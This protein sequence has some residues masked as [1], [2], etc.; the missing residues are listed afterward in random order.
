MLVRETQGAEER[1]E[2]SI[3]DQPDMPVGIRREPDVSIGQYDGGD[4]TAEAQ[5]RA[6][7]AAD[8]DAAIGAI[9]IP[10]DRGDEGG[11]A[12]AEQV[13]DPELA[14]EPELP[15]AS[16]AGGRDRPPIEPPDYVAS[17]EAAGEG[18]HIQ[19]VN[20]TS[21]VGDRTFMLN[22]G[23]PRQDL[24]D[25]ALDKLDGSMFAVPMDWHR[26]AYRPGQPQ[27]L[28]RT[29]FVD[30]AADPELAAKHTVYDN[31]ETHDARNALEEMDLAPKVGAV[32]RSEEAQALAQ[33]A[34]F[35]GIDYVA[36]VAASV[37]EDSAEDSAEV[38]VYP[39]QPGH[40][41]EGD[42]LI[43]GDP[44]PGTERARVD[45]VLAEMREVF[46]AHAI[47]PIGLTPDSVVID[48]DQ[49]HITDA[50][51]MR[52]FEP[53]LPSLEAGQAARYAEG[54][55][56]PER[57]RPLPNESRP[58]IRPLDVDTAIAGRRPLGEVDPATAPAFVAGGPASRVVTV[59]NGFTGES[60]MV[61]ID[62]TSM[63]T[64]EGE[65]AVRK[66]L[67]D[68]P[69]LGSRGA[70]AHV[71]GDYAGSIREQARGPGWNDIL[72]KT[73]TS[74]GVGVVKIV[75]VLGSKVVQLNTGDGSTDVYDIEL[76][77]T[78]IHTPRRP[79]VS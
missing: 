66:L 76:D 45:A 60:G 16:D 25:V 53:D 27:D 40:T 41:P 50:E 57:T 17:G 39:Y 1:P 79:Q 6:Y 10:E 65:E 24:V 26:S 54:E 51:R 37:G 18:G 5:T 74:V 3:V 2:P 64:G 55:W 68:V 30:N 21:Y 33:A 52:S 44:E 72:A 46:Q 36:P 62:D 34:G 38:V 58:V 4:A 15:P 14:E 63:N 70:I 59:T 67:A 42:T 12:P 32:V 8:R 20:Q 73:L 56:R 69:S 49:V 71:V 7:N 77:L 48:N 61:H 31:S 29:Y 43:T 19:Y 23:H 9:S 47:D 11:A 22:R 28:T 35:T 78:Y 13:T 75:P